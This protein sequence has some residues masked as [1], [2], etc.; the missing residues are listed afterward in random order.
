ME[1]KLTKQ[2]R[3]F[4][5]AYLVSM[6]PRSAALEA[7]YAQ[8]T[9]KT[10]AFSWVSDSKCPPHKA[11][12]YNAIQRELVKRSELLRCTSIMVLNKLWLLANFNIKK[13]IV[14]PDDGA[15]PYYD[16]SEAT[17]SDWY[18]VDELLV[19]KVHRGSGAEKV[20][21]D[22]IKVK[23][24]SKLKALELAGRHVDIQA[25]K[26]KVEVDVFDRAKVIQAARQRVA[27]RSEKKS[28][29]KPKR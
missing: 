7:G 11:H 22:R 5:H 28:T 8:T 10:K 14:V 17:D 2:E 24:A 27:E 12:V 20:T 1:I 15:Q 23:A 21:I 4:V 13:F 25:F 6:N 26:D 9:S 18:C 29:N 3:I 19:D 16:F